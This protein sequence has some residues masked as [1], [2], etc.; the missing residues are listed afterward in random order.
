[1][2]PITSIRKALAD[3]NLLGN[4]L[5]GSSWHPWRTL[6]IAAAGEELTDEERETFTRLTGRE[7]EPGQRVEE[8]VAIVGR[9]GGKSRAMAV[10]ACY[11]AA[12]CK[13]NLVRGETGIVLLIAPDQRQAKVALGYATAAIEGSP[14][15]RKLIVNCTADTVELNNGIS[16]EVR[17]ASFRRLRGP[18]YIAAIC[19]E[20]A[21]W[22]SDEISANADT[23]IINAVRPGLSTTAGPLI[24]ASSPYAKRGVLWQAHKQ[25]HGKDGDPLILV[26]QGE[27]RIYLSSIA[28][29]NVI[30]LQRPPIISRS[31]ARIWK[32]SCRSKSCKPA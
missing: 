30:A 31:S 32:H 27:S 25:H 12:L 21:F 5:A 11:L 9:R 24:I 13:H 1:M 15:L 14:V 16:I 20:A 6:L 3:P 7:R 10:L 28:P 4:V 26:A 2:K 17:A 23:E 18:T 29:W 19:D 22:Y 8:L